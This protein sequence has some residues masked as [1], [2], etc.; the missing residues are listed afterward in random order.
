MNTHELMDTLVKH[1]S[2]ILTVKRNQVKVIKSRLSNYRS[3]QQAQLA[4]FADY[5]R[6]E[7]KEIPL[8]ELA[9][10]DDTMTRLRISLVSR[11]KALEGI[12]NIE[13]AK[14]F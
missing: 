2:I 6:L 4:E 11:G 13:P 9:E 10:P 5:R 14:D 3:R 7:Y 12:T 8:H 1:E